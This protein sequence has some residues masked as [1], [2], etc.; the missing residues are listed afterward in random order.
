MGKKK[1]SIRQIIAFVLAMIMII[2]YTPLTVLAAE[3]DDDYVTEGEYTSTSNEGVQSPL[4]DS[5]TFREDCF[6]RS[7]FLGCD[8][9]ATLS[10]EVCEASASWYGSEDTGL[11]LDYTNNSA[12]LV[13]M[14]T[15][16]GFEDV[17]TNEYYKLVM[18]ENSAAAA[19]GH[20]EIKAGGK[21]YTLLAIIPRSAGYKQEWAGNFT[22]GSGDIH[23]GFKAG[24]DEILRFVKNYIDTYAISGDLKVWI[25]GHSR[26]AALSNLLGGFFAGGGIEYFGDTVSITP[27]DVYCY[28]FATPANIKDGADKSAVLSVE[29]YRG[30]T[31]ANY[32]NDTSGASFISTQ[33]GTIDIDGEEFG[34][35]WNFVAPYDF[36]TKVPPAGWNFDRYGT[37][38]TVS[39]DG[40]VSVDEMLAQ[41]NTHFPYGYNEFVATG[42]FRN[43]EWKTFDLPNLEIAASTDED[44]PE[45]VGMSEFMYQRINN[46]LISPAPTNSDYSEGGYEETLKAVAGLY[47][48]LLPQFHNISLEDKDLNVVKPLLFTYLSYAGEKLVNEGRAADEYAATAIALEELLSYFTGQ[49]I[50]NSTF[51]INDFIILMA[52]Y[53]SDNGDSKLADTVFEGIAGAIPDGFGKDMMIV[54]LGN[55]NAKVAA[56]E[57]VELK[58]LLKSYFYAFVYGAE[59]GSKADIDQIA[60]KP[61]EARLILYS[62]LPLLITDIDST[63]VYQIIGTDDKGSLDGS[64]SFTGGVQLI[65]SMLM[66]EKDEEENVI[67]TFNTI[68]EA[69]D[70]HMNQ[71]IDQ[72]LSDVVDNSLTIYGEDYYNMVKKHY[73]TLKGHIPELRKMLT[74]AL[75]ETG[76]NFDTKSNIRN[77]TT[78]IGNI[79]IIP[80]AH[81]NEINVAW[82][83][84]VEASDKGFPDHYIEHFAAV[85]EDCVTDGAK[86]YWLLHDVDGETYY[87]D[88]YLGEKTTKEGIVVPKLG[89]KPGDM[90]IENNIEPDYDRKGSYEEVIYCTICGAEIQR[91]KKTVP[92]KEKEDEEEP[93][94]TEEMPTEENTEEP[95]EETP[96][97]TTEG[98]TESTEVTTEKK[99]E[100]VTEAKKSNKNAS[101]GT[102]DDSMLFAGMI[103]MFAG[104]SGSVLLIKKRKRN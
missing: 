71:L 86:E 24:R 51:T 87:L 7:S 89:H 2:G 66:T 18:Q 45:D 4:T 76:G 55:Y 64:G 40:E 33:S 96:P 38:K 12:N 15:K 69:A 54:F 3:T 67:A 78:F 68:D 8:H 93:G 28:T 11:E 75:F 73:D 47:G 42:D 6:M 102:G 26:G 99:T 49:E 29:G 80:C 44:L 20:R 1:C 60:N 16:M 97:G 92:K 43:F 88:K 104:L 23:E 37:T 70:Y 81:Y 53:L 35:I 94:A 41:L 83:R 25:T 36:I 62:V 63:T 61:E 95:T 79:G 77:V 14:L 52:T 5:F 32:K 84:A 21:T 103:L 72:L 85:K 58:D 56:G 50:D 98:I 74:S 17:A 46:G 10:S 19:V 22:V 39:W 91:V 59:E 100:T 90:V 101:P 13:D 31:D 27:E 30:D 82:T 9:L 48:M 57:K 65:L 34:G